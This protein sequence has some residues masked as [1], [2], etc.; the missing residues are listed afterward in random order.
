[1][2]QTLEEPLIYIV[3]GVAG[4]LDDALCYLGPDFFLVDVGPV[5]EYFNSLRVLDYDDQ[6][7][8]AAPGAGR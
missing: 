7:G 8:R 5:P 6:A 3:S 4:K 1:M 2:G